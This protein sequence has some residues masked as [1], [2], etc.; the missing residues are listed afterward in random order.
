MT[1]E[2][3]LFADPPE[4]DATGLGKVRCMLAT[5]AGF[6]VHCDHGILQLSLDQFDSFRRILTPPKGFRP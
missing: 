6:A 3:D 5:E 4:I 1:P 2:L